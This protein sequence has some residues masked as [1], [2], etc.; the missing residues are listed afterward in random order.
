[1]SLSENC[2]FRKIKS[3]QKISFPSSS[4]RLLSKTEILPVQL[5]PIISY[6]TPTDRHREV[7]MRLVV[8]EDISNKLVE[9]GEERV[10]GAKTSEVH[11]VI[12][13]LC[14]LQGPHY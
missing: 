7:W 3:S 13:V 9:H 14:M 11:D 1:M 4:H 8:V 12:Q 6:T 2:G 5:S 10:E